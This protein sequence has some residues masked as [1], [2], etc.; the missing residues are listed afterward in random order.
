MYVSIAEVD[1]NNN[2][3]NDNMNGTITNAKKFWWKCRPPLAKEF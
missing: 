3:N 2:N 1:D